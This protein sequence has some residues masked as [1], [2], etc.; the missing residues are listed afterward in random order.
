MGA[1][2]QAVAMKRKGHSEPVVWWLL[3]KAKLS[4]LLWEALIIEL[5]LVD[6]ARGAILQWRPDGDYSAV[7]CDRA[8]EGSAGG[9]VR[10]E[11]SCQ[12]PSSSVVLS[13]Q[14]GRAAWAANDSLTHCNDHRP[15]PAQANAGR[16]RD[17]IEQQE[18]EKDSRIGNVN[19]LRF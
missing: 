11:S 8:A 15:L 4:Q 9:I 2:E 1:Y 19:R 3:G 13:I 14:A 18:V 7:Q 10:R 17:G 6:R 5:E 16:S 12:F